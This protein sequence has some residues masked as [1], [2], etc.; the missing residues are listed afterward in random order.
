MDTLKLLTSPL[1]FPF[2]LVWNVLAFLGRTF[3]FVVTLS[4]KVA[5]ILL[6]IFGLI[7]WLWW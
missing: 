7:M 5:I 1:W 4:L 2:W 6:A 3:W